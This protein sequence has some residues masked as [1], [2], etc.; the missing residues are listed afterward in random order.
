MT[1]SRDSIARHIRQRRHDAGL[2]GEAL[3]TPF[4]PPHRFIDALRKAGIGCEAGYDRMHD[5]EFPTTCHLMHYY[6]RR[7]RSPT[8]QSGFIAL[9]CDVLGMRPR[10][11]S[12]LTKAVLLAACEEILARFKGTRWSQ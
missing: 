10:F 6:L 3:I 1:I 9:C 11:D 4:D 8:A 2:A 7:K 12:W 5:H